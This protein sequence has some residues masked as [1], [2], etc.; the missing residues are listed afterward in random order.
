[1]FLF[2]NAGPWFAILR[3][4]FTDRVIVQCLTDFIWVGMSST[5]NKV[6]CVW[7]AHIMNLLRMNVHKLHDYYHG[8]KVIAVGANKLHLCFFPSICAYSIVKEEVIEF[9]YIKPLKSSLTYVTFLAQTLGDS[10]RSVI[11][12]FIKQYRE[13]THCILVRENLAPELL[14]YGKINVQD[15]DPS[16]GHL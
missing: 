15:G 11:V 9:K 5:L 4:V 16:Y 13:D 8:L 2:A 6:N 7:V 10:P 3:A 1:M 14:Y 12:K